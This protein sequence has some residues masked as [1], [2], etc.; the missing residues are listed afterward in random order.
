VSLFDEDQ[1]N[2]LRFIEILNNE[3]HYLNEEIQGKKRII[4]KNFGPN[5]MTFV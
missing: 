4:C 1:D 2:I 3:E 5:E